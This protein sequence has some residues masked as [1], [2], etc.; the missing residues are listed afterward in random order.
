MNNKRVTPSHFPSIDFTCIPRL[1]DTH[2]P[3]LL[4]F[5]FFFPLLL[6][7]GNYY[8]HKHTRTCP[9]LAVFKLCSVCHRSEAKVNQIENSCPLCASFHLSLGRLSFHSFLSLLPSGA[10][11]RIITGSRTHSQSQV[12]L[13]NFISPKH[14]FNLK[15]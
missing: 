6:L 5:L 4:T 1:L 7:T 15:A 10:P 3:I 11:N 9:P 13:R 12:G 2:L 8:T 14:I